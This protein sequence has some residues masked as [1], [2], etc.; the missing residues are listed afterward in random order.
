M[1]HHAPTR[2]AQS[3]HLDDATWTKG[4]NAMAFV[5]M[6]G[7]IASVLAFISDSRQFYASY[8]VNFV[9]FTTLG[10]GA[11]LF[12]AIQHLTGS[13][14]SVTVRRQMENIMAATPVSAVLFLVILAGM[15][16]LYEWS[17]PEFYSA[18]PVMQFKMN[19][20][21]KNFFVARAVI[22]FAV[23]TL[24]AVKLYGASLQQED[25]DSRGG[26]RKA[27]WWSGPAV[28]LLFV[29]A[30]MAGVDW[31][32]SLSAHWYSTMFGIYIYS[33]GAFGFFALLI[34]IC[35]AFRKA[36]ILTEYITLEHYHDLGKWLFAMTIF[37]AYIAFSQYMLIWYANL[38]EETI[39]FKVRMEGSWTWVSAL[40]LVGHFIIPFLVLLTRA[41][42]RNLNVLGGAA[43]W[44]LFM[45]YVDIHWLVMPTIHKHDFHLSW[46]DAATFLLIGGFFGL[47]FWARLRNRSLIAIGDPRFKQGLHFH[48]V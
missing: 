29:T 13:A 14:W 17:H 27:E 18:D 35:L 40:L 37:W 21:N 23:W 7:L 6:V 22:Y 11:M 1:D 30:T 32:M 38:P 2:A 9:F 47:A 45:H 3:H 15:P 31:V 4:R 19:F 26:S 12:V 8:L 36:G 5:A 46:V 16:V 39:F 48:N 10:L 33:G 43:A 24:L 41:S 34:L 25:G 44:C 28:A 20:F 42:K